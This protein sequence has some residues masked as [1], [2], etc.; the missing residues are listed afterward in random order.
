MRKIFLVMGLCFVAFAAL[1]Q[2]R[3]GINTGQGVQIDYSNPKVFEI[4]EIKYTGLRILDE[5]ALTSFAGIKVG[6]RIPIPGQ[7]ISDAI[8]RLWGQ[9]IIADVQFWLTKTEGDRAWIEVKLTERPRILRYNITGVTSTQES[10]LK[11]QINIIGKVASSPLIKNSE[12]LVKKYFEEKGY[13]NTTVK[14][15]QSGDSVLVDGTSL[16]FEV[17]KNEKVKIRKIHFEG[18]EAFEDGRLKGPLKNTNEKARFWLFAHLFD[19]VFKTRPK[20]AVRYFAQSDTVATGE[21]KQ[22][23][24][25]N[26]KLNILKSSKFIAADFEEDKKSL[27][28]FYNSKGYRD[29]EIVSDEVEKIDDEY[30]DVKIKVD[31]GNKYYIRNIEWVGNYKYTDAFLTEKLGIEKGDVYNRER[32]EQRTNFDGQ[33]GDDINSLYSDDGYLFFRLDVVEVRAENDSIDLEMR[34]SEGE[35][36]TIKRIILK[37]NDRT[38][39]HVVL[40][41]I[42]TLPG[43]KYSR[44]ELIRTIRELG[45]LGYFDPEQINPQ[46]IPNLQDGTVDIMFTLV[47]KSSDQIQLSGGFGGPFGFVGTVGLSLN[48]FSIKNIGN[49]DKWRPYPS[50]DGQKLSLQLQSNGRRFQS[51][52]LIFSE[53]WLGGK[54]PNN[55]T[56]SLNRTANRS[57]DPYNNNELYGYLKSSGITV[58]LGRRLRWPDD[59]FQIQNSISYQF[60]NVY[61]FG[62]T[63]GFE[64]GQSNSLTFNTVISRSNID[65]PQY[66]KLGTQ[67]TLAINATP[68]WSAL[69]PDYFEPDGEGNPISEEK[70]Y[71]FIEYHKWM[72]DLSMFIPLNKKFVVN[73]RAHMG[74][75]GS[76]TD[77]TDSGPFE[78]FFLG[79]SGLNGANNFVIGQ[80]I[81]GLR[82]YD[83]NS[84]VPVDPVTGFRGGIVYNKFVAELRYPVS[85]AP[86]STIYLL[87]FA[88]AGNAWNKFSEY[89]P[90]NLFRSAGFGARVFLPAFG[91]LGIDWAYGFDSDLDLGITA[92]SQIHFTIGQQLR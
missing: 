17:D 80:D 43:Q 85:L 83:D 50:G 53:P 66:P 15:V 75:I 16:T 14:T 12:L 32:I 27:I 51:Y 82:G 22:F 47:E 21:V 88:E 37:G 30:I 65:N 87:T 79:G 44:K 6:D 23:I 73:A 69:M 28:N 25:D 11:D 46:P 31:E 92:G 86:T 45:Q 78:R 8:K 26:V 84:I 68:P 59:Y 61:N 58:G 42:R 35:Q 19:Q 70:R 62:Q 91:L 10:D 67:F 24:N 60:Y 5:R 56:V 38:S 57:L 52:S 39:D 89:T 74:F 40:R 76:Y 41:E 7:E 81:I 36:A 33:N 55:F 72:M 18:N 54:K 64:T 1:S 77:R 71:K 20:S 63:L 48:N 49:W 3:Y 90:R 2:E 29:A 9:G 4:A 34:M 13:L